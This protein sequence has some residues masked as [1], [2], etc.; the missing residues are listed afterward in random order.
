MLDFRSDRTKIV[1]E[2]TANMKPAEGHSIARAILV[3]GMMI[4][5]AIENSALIGFEKLADAIANHD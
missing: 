2:E 3:A 5:D 4:A 1:Q